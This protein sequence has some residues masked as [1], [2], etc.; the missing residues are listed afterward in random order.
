MLF[1]NLIAQAEALAFG[2]IAD[3]VRAAGVPD[4]LVAHRTFE[5]NRPTTLIVADRLTPH[6]LGQLVALYEHKVFV[7]SV[8]WGINAFDQFGVELGKKLAGTIKNSKNA[9]TRHLLGKLR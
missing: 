7:E 2:K 6:V 5:G 9:S 4:D 8:V 3:E 1:A